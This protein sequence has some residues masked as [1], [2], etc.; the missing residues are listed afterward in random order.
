MAG[1]GKTGFAGLPFRDQL[2]YLSPNAVG[3]NIVPIRVRSR[4]EA[5]RHCNSLCPKSTD[6]LSDGGILASDRRNIA[7]HQMFEVANQGSRAAHVFYTSASRFRP[8]GSF[9]FL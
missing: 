2:G 1:V 6:H 8:T 3:I 9:S 4:R 7:A 5:R